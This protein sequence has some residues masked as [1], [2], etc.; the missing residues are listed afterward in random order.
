MAKPVSFPGK[1]IVIGFGQVARAFMELLDRHVE[2]AAGK[3]V[4]DRLACPPDFT[5]FAQV[6]WTHIQEEIARGSIRDVISR[7][8]GRGDMIVNL[9]AGV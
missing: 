6:G 9:T 1:I 2:R 4:I 5:R 7:H 3:V 8:A